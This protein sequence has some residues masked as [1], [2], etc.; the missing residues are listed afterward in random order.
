MV[1]ITAAEDD[2]IDIGPVGQSRG[3]RL[4]PQVERMACGADADHWLARRD[5]IL[6]QVDL[7]LRQRPP[8]GTNEEHVR[9]ADGVQARKTRLTLLV[10]KHQRH[11]IIFA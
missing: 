5:V 7:L 4:I 8:A 10:E 2:R 6:D 1:G 11:A 9:N 3:R